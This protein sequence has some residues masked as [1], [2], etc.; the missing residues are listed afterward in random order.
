MCVKVNEDPKNFTEFIKLTEKRDE[1]AIFLSAFMNDGFD[2]D[3]L[4]SSSI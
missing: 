3:R 1:F 4:V 2:P